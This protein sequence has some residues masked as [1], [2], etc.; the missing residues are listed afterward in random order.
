MVARLL[1]EQKVPGSSPGAPTRRPRQRD[2]GFRAISPFFKQ[3]QR[4]GLHWAVGTPD[5]WPLLEFSCGI[6]RD[7][8]TAFQSSLAG[9]APVSFMKIDGTI[10]F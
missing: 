3:G 6:F 1:W 8:P 9:A 7:F 5:V 2:E 10:N 4:Q